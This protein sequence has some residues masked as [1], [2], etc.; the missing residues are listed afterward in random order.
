MTGS[1]LAWVIGMMAHA[2]LTRDDVIRVLGDVDEAIVVDVIATGASAADL[3]A[4]V[5][6]LQD[7]D[8]TWRTDRTDPIVVTLCEVLD[9]V[10]APS[11]EPEYIG[12][13]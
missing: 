1:R 6:Q 5:A 8:T 11:D 10:W 3:T 12:T 4:A 7:A 2:P 9:P 13:D